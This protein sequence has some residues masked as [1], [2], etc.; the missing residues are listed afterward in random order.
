MTSGLGK[1]AYA[2]FTK[3]FNIYRN[4]SL[5]LE[6]V[7]VGLG[8]PSLSNKSVS[9]IFE[10]FGYKTLMEKLSTHSLQTIPGVNYIAIESLYDNQAYIDEVISLLKNEP[11]LLKNTK[12]NNIIYNIKVCITGALS[13]SRKAFLDICESYGIHESSIA[14]ADILVTNDTESG[15]TKN[16]EAQKRGTKIMDEDTFRKVYFI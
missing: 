12:E 11:K 15:S 13:V 3:L 6:K 9:K 2:K 10:L 5:D 7:F 16:K 14:K 8:L 4:E 1:V